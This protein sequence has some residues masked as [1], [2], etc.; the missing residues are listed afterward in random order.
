MARKT[1]DL[2]R[3]D[4]VDTRL[5]A[6]QQSVGQATNSD[7]QMSESLSKLMNLAPKAQGL[8]QQ[9]DISNQIKERDI[10]EQV[11]L[12][13][14]TASLE[15]LDTIENPVI[16]NRV[17]GNLKV[18][19][20]A[21]EFESR[22]ASGEWS[23]GNWSD[24][25]NEWNEKSNIN[26]ETSSPATKVGFEQ[27]S[28]A[29]LR[30]LRQSFTRQKIN[31]EQ[32]QSAITRDA[33]LYNWQTTVTGDSPE[34]IFKSFESGSFSNGVKYNNQQ[35]NASYFNAARSALAE[36]KDISNILEAAKIERKDGNSLWSGNAFGYAQL[37]EVNRKNT[38]KKKV[39]DIQVQANMRENFN[40][41][42]EA[43]Q[44]DFNN[45][46][47]F[48]VKNIKDKNR[49]MRDEG[50][51]TD[52][53][54]FT[55]DKNIN[56]KFEHQ[57]G[58]NN[59]TSIYSISLEEGNH[60]SKANLSAYIATLNSTPKGQKVVK[61]MSQGVLIDLLSGEAGNDSIGL[62]KL[63]GT[64]DLTKGDYSSIGKV[65]FDTGYFPAELKSHMSKTV[66][67]PGYEKK[68]DMIMAAKTGGYLDALDVS[69]AE[70]MD[71]TEYFQQGLDNISKEDRINNQKELAA[72]GWKDK[73]LPSST[74]KKISNLAATA[75]SEMDIP[76]ILGF[77]KSSEY[78]GIL[79]DENIESS[80]ELQLDI[81]R[82]AQ[83][84][85][86]RNTSMSEE[87]AIDKATV[88]T[89]GKTWTI[90]PSGK[91][92]FLGL[93]NQ[94]AAVK[95]K[96]GI[97]APNFTAGSKILIEQFEK[98]VNSNESR[99]LDQLGIDS[100][101]IKMD[102]DFDITGEYYLVDQDG[103]SLD[104]KTFTDSNGRVIPTRFNGEF[105][106]KLFNATGKVK[107]KTEA[108]E[109]DKQRLINAANGVTNEEFDSSQSGN[110][111][112]IIQG[113][114]NTNIK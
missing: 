89:L 65:F 103:K 63:Q 18:N 55:N 68:V 60:Q 46:E 22:I 50:I 111:E 106:I 67:T 76:G 97:N 105:A 77:L 70:V 69:S 39:L 33:N 72:S 8:L 11:S 57:V 108:L 71:A 114:R 21:Q 34:E 43:F 54:F 23:G 80:L 42:I 81:E 95:V 20:Q 66:G 5:Q 12:L 84:Y 47:N 19:S 51:I 98:R 107:Q 48:G 74:V 113:F 78:G 14:E 96:K 44:L 9:L 93:S 53:Q 94:Q 3:P 26:L 1:Q 41:E 15:T 88:D 101:G 79:F 17:E 85:I 109:A 75:S 73:V 2:G 37:E 99:N 13:S 16:R 45:E 110:A 104:G 87:D 59:A 112:R 61:D 91:T 28:A 6:V 10:N 24:V 83:N 92:S 38:N 90:V 86:K 31:Y 29:G 40:N 62:A 4:Q 58:V 100:V 64:Q 102:P 35:K 52:A 27:A 7:L 49:Q 30:A 25:L 82:R 36:G 56:N 32:N